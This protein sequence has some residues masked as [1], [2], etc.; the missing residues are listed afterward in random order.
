VRLLFVIE[1]TPQA[2]MQIMQRNEVV[3]RILR[4]G[5]VQL[6]VLNPETSEIQVY[7]K[8]KFNRYEPQQVELPRTA[9]SIDWY[10]GWR[11]HLPFAEIESTCVAHVEIEDDEG[12][13]SI[14]NC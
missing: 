13:C 7:D 6:A 8:G 14:T 4:N 1:T 3:G 12:R 5:W 2:I 10:R 9:S 11:D